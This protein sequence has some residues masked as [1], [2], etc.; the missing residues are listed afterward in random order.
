V[1]ALIRISTCL[2][3]KFRIWKLSLSFPPQLRPAMR[4]C[5]YMEALRRDAPLEWR[6]KF[7]AYQRLRQTLEDVRLIGKLLASFRWQET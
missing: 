1:F 6:H 2:Y 5:D 7:L 3:R 4:L